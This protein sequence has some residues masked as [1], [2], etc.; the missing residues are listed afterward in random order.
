MRRHPEE[1]H[2]ASH[3]S[4]ELLSRAT[5][6]FNMLVSVSELAQ[7]AAQILAIISFDLVQTKTI[8]FIC[9]GVLSFYFDCKK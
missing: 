7:M 2:L 8:E 5:G 6:N 4:P 9:C 3:V 1:P